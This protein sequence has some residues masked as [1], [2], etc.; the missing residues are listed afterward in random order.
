[1]SVWNNDIDAFSLS[2][3]SAKLLISS[4]V[5]MSRF[6]EG[7]HHRI[8]GSV[9]ITVLRSRISVQYV[10]FFGKAED[11]ARAYKKKYKYIFRTLY[12]LFKLNESFKMNVN[13]CLVHE[14]RSATKFKS[15]LVS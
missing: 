5:L 3:M 7:T 1:M 9:Y 8:H 2:M 10:A 12:N 11:D 6:R 4:F 13:R 14:K 15:K